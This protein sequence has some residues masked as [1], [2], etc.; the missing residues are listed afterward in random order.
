MLFPTVEFAAFF[1]VVFSLNWFLK[2]CQR[3]RKL[4]LVAASY[5]FY[6]FWDWRFMFLLLNSSLINYFFGIWISKEQVD[7]KRKA[8]VTAAVAINLCILGVF[9]YYGFFLSTLSDLLS[10]LGFARDIPIAQII[11]PVGISFYTFQAIS[12]IVDVYRKKIEANPSL[13][14]TVLYI[15][16][17]PQLMAGP[18]VR[19]NVFMPQL[20]QPP[21][22]TK[23]DAGYA[24]ILI[25]F[26]LVK[27]TIIASYIAS[28][29]VEPAFN[30][31]TIYGTVDLLFG[32]YGYAVQIYCD[33]SA[34]S[35]IAIGVALLLGF[36]YPKNFDQP[37]RANS[38]QDFWRRWH[39]SLST[40]LR[41]YVY[42]SFGGN[43][44]GRVKT[45]RNL[46]VTMLLGGLWH[47]AAWN[48]VFWGALHGA[49]LMLERMIHGTAARF[50]AKP[51]WLLNGLAV[52]WVFHF[53]CFGWLFFRASSFAA[54]S[55]YLLAFANTDLSIVLLDRFTLT[56]ILL[57][58]TLHFVPKNSNEFIALQFSRLPAVAQGAALGL[59]L[60]ILD[61]IGPEGVPPFIY[62]Q[63]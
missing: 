30:D 16:F 1:V 48:F 54:G 33:F 55:E 2:D 8:L 38:L 28:R 18:I 50:N 53:V 14:D 10:Q 31:P 24:F 27:K 58:M 32:I 4:M 41:D 42:I 36:K 57:G 49:G 40:W 13:V 51:H 35:D 20:N 44:G 26:G 12:Y 56:L 43:R 47:G 7:N 17:F 59:G 62:F 22:I 45:Y 63:F 9:K 19:A 6:G 61:A 34:Y 3:Q 25:F 39:I 21:E 5:F 29:I 11:L 15:S 37:Y 23:E 60:M 46:F 52:V